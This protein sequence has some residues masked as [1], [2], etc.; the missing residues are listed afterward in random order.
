MYNV[1]IETIDNK[2]SKASLH[3]T[4]YT[5]RTKSLPLKSAID[6]GSLVRPHTNL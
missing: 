4:F 2:L 6:L 1:H 5:W 3:T